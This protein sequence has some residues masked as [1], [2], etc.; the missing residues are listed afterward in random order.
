MSTPLRRLLGALAFALAGVA[1]LPAH[2][3]PYTSMY[4]FGDSLSDTGNLNVATGGTQP[5]PGQPYFNGRFSDGPVWVE[6]LAAG[7]GLSADVA[8]ALLGG[9]NYAFAGARMGTSSTNAGRARMKRRRFATWGRTT[10]PRR[11]TRAMEMSTSIAMRCRWCIETAVF[12][13]HLA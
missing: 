2:A 10:L 3:G 7:L 6:T 11:T 13:L 5:A 9:N 12:R 1:S 4:V 8:P